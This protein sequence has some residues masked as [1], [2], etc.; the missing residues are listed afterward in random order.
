MRVQ[1]KGSCEVSHL[2]AFPTPLAGS[3]VCSSRGG[4][5]LQHGRHSP[6]HPVA[7][8]NALHSGSML[9]FDQ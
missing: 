2:N 1:M 7:M 8:H 4:V 3:A 5:V 6:L 9:C